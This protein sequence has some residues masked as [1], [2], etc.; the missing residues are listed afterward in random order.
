MV[1]KKKKSKNVFSLVLVTS[2]FGSLFV[3]VHSLNKIQCYILVQISGQ[4]RLKSRN[5]V[6]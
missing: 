5:D 4:R 1:K 6:F 2:H 3:I